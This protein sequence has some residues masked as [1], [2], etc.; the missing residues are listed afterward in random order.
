MV[1]WLIFNPSY[2]GLFYRMWTIGGGRIPPPL[3]LRTMNGLTKKYEVSIFSMGNLEQ[4]SISVYPSKNYSKYPKS[5]LEHKWFLSKMLF[6]RSSVLRNLRI[7]AKKTLRSRKKGHLT[8]YFLILSNFCFMTTPQKM[9]LST[10]KS[11][12]PNLRFLKKGP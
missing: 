9:P 4:I 1:F 6:C 10:L 7:L 12:C 3:L 5:T 11:Q 8:W 2:I